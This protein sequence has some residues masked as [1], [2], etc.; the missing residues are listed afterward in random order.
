MLLFYVSLHIVPAAEFTYAPWTFS[1]LL[2]YTIGWILSK[3]PM[4]DPNMS[5]HSLIITKVYTTR[6]RILLVSFAEDVRIMFLLNVFAIEV[7]S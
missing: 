7:A 1:F 4:I 6:N 2:Q 3:V 5:I